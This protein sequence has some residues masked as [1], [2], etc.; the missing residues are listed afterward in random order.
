MTW[1]ALIICFALTALAAWSGAI[2]SPGVA[3]GDW[4]EGLVKPAWNPPAWVF[5]PVWTV[6]YV[7]IAVAGWLVWRSAGI[8]L[9][10]GFWVLQLVLNALWSQLFFAMHRPDLAL[11]DIAALWLSILA[12]ILAARTTSPAAALMMVPYWAWVTFA[13]VLNFRIWQL[14]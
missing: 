12:F 3:P 10:L 7:M 8:S 13:A 5:G 2:V 14:N 11:I 1:I 4:Y 9:A 6:L